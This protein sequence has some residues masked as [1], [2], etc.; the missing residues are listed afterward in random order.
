M[1]FKNKR[2]T[3]NS[4]KNLTG[5][6]DIAGLD[7]NKKQKSENINKRTISE[8]E[9]DLNSKLSDINQK[10]KNHQIQMIVIMMIMKV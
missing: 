4:D 7:S 10:K 3:I 1:A 6:R 9:N 5:F 2:I 8:S